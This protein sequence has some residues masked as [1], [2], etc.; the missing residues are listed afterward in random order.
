MEVIIQEDGRKQAEVDRGTRSEAFDDLPG[1]L[2]FFVGVRSGQVEVELVGVDLGEEVSPAGEGF[3]IEEFVFFDAVDGFDVAL[4]SVRGRGNTHMLAVPER[5]GEVAF[6]FATVVG[7]PGQI[8]QRDTVAIQVLLDAG[9]KDG[10]GCRAAFFGKG[11]EQQAA[12][13]IAGSVLDQG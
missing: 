9:S 5:F 12:A 1:S 2:I 7:L 11:P 13:N 4:V 6:E 10:A 8:P 3:Q